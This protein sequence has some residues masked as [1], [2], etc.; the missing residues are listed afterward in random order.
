MS[1]GFG[2]KYIHKFFCLPFL[3]L[4]HVTLVGLLE[5][6]K[7]ESEITVHELD[8]YQQ[9]EDADYDR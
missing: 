6:N 8:L 7:I 4:Q 9:S 1:N 2:L 5:R 3:Q